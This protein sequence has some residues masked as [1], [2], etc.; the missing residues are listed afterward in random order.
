MDRVIGID[1]GATKM[2]GAVVGRDGQI[3]GS[4]IETPTVVTDAGTSLDMLL[5][6]LANSKNGIKHA[7]IGSP[8]FLDREKGIVLG[9]VNLP[10]FRKYDIAGHLQRYGLKMVIANDV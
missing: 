2:K 1:I 8:G 9:A 5:K 10:S 7:G 4:V 6:E 3:E